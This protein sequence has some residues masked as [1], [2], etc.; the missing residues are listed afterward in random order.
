MITKTKLEKIKTLEECQKYLKSELIKYTTLF[1]K[2]YTDYEKKAFTEQI[3]AY[4]CNGNYVVVCSNLLGTEI[5][6]LKIYL[7]KTKPSSPHP[8]FPIPMSFVKDAKEFGFGEEI[9]ENSDLNLDSYI[10]E[11]KQKQKDL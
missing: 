8:L 10:E 1:N 7:T 6:N 2:A 11:I 3:K 5:K 9:A 4:E